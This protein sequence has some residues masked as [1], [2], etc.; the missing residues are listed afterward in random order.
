MSIV[1]ALPVGNQAYDL[2]ELTNFFNFFQ[3]LLTFLLALYVSRAVS[4][5]WD[6]RVQSIGALWDS[7]CKLN[8]WASAWWSHSAGSEIGTRATVLRYGLLSHALLFKEA[9]GELRESRS[10][11]DAGLSDLVDS[12]LLKHAEALQ[13]APLPFKAYVVWAW[14]TTFWTRALTSGSNYGG[15]CSDAPAGKEANRGTIIPIPHAAHLMPL[16]MDTCGRARDAISAGLTHVTTQQPFAYVHLLALGCW[17]AVVLNALLAGLKLAYLD[18][19]LLSSGIAWPGPS[20]WPLLVACVGRLF[21]LPIMYDGL[22]GLSVAL[23][24]PFLS[25]T[26]FP[27]D[28][29]EHEMHAECTAMAKGVDGIDA[30]RWWHAAGTDRGKVATRAK[31]EWQFG[32]HKCTASPQPV[33]PSQGHSLRGRAHALARLVTLKRIVTS[34]APAEQMPRE[35]QGASVMSF[36]G[37]RSSQQREVLQRMSDI[38]EYEANVRHCDTY[39]DVELGLELPLPLPHATEHD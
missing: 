6:I 3:G 36:A 20:S 21:V 9:R 27:S 30:T 15:A 18:P 31:R 33:P 25:S 4:R 22:L 35:E 14:H 5:W 29:F 7:I 11:A 24:N 26:G 23:E 32:R 34:V 13:L 10:A 8:M 2:D 19:K 38:E 28:L 1:G 17:V 39:R 12:N 37:L 16:V